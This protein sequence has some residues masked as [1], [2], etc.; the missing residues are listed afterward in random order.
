MKDKAT[1]RFQKCQFPFKFKDKTHNGCIDFIDI[2]N[3]KKVPGD[4][5]CST[6]VRGV[7]R[8]HVTGGSHY[9][10]CNDSCQSADEVPTNPTSEIT[11]KKCINTSTPAN[12]LKIISALK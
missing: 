8:E 1:K 7:D 11:N 10:D 2:R 12:F 3:G 5:W 4:P 9:G 6:K